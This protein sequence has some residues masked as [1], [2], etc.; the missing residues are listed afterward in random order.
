MLHAP[1][2]S[3]T[4]RSRLCGAANTCHRRGRKL[5]VARASG[6]ICPAPHPSGGPY[7]K[8]YALHR[9]GPRSGPVRCGM[10][11]LLADYLPLAIFIGVSLVLVLALLVAPLLVA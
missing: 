10:T 11:S 1:A 7:R 4:R 6:T 3:G 2:N 5:S 8:P 9:N